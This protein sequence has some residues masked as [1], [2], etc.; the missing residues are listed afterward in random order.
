MARFTTAIVGAFA[1]FALAAPV[2]AD[3]LRRDGTVVLGKAQLFPS[4]AGWGTARPRVIFNGGTRNSR[5]WNLRWSGWGTASAH[6][7]GLTWIYRP[8]GGYYPRPAAIELRATR[9]GR[10][11]ANSPRAYRYLEARSA[12]RPGGPLG[13]W[14]AWG[15]WGRI[16][17]RP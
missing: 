14:Y 4:G 17:Q 7:R 13:R 9:I 1:L 2:C 15:G 12:V 5:A 10:C 16:C 8:D 11:A 3:V 6:A